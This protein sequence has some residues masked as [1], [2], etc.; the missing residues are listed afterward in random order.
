MAEF[1]VVPRPRSPGLHEVSCRAPEVATIMIPLRR[2]TGKFR[3]SR[4]SHAS[5]GAG[6]STDTSVDAVP[7][8]RRWPRYC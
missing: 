7:R 5:A 1:K 4:A 2:M 3:K 8:P 6:A